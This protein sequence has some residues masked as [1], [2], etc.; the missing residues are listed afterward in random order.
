MSCWA[1]LCRYRI[2][3]LAEPTRSRTGNRPAFFV[4]GHPRPRNEIVPIN[5][6]QR[7]RCSPSEQCPATFQFLLPLNI[8]LLSADNH[9]TFTNRAPRGRRLPTLIS[10]LPA[11]TFPFIFTS[12]AKEAPDRNNPITAINNSLIPS[13]ALNKQHH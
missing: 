9:R 12:S 11:S 10:S 1:F 6:A 4:S 3:L 2:G 13:N 5:F 8:Y 7:S